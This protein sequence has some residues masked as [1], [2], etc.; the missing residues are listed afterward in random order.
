MVPEQ[1]VFNS[2]LL[3]ISFNI[4]F[5]YMCNIFI[6]SVHLM[7]IR[8]KEFYV[9]DFVIIVHIATS[10]ECKYNTSESDISSSIISSF[11]FPL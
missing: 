7:F 10:L 3:Q 11:S 6:T 1:L 2:W 9:K 5:Y 8:Y 4:H